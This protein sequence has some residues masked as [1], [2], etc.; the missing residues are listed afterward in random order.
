M[1][2]TRAEA[3]SLDRLDSIGTGLCRPESV[4]THRSGLVFTSDWTAGGGVSVIAPDGKV[5]RVLSDR[6]ADPLRPNGI[7]LLE[8]G[9]FLLAHLGAETGGLYEMDATGQFTPVI[10]HL[11]G[12]P[13]PPSNF[14]LLD[15]EGDLWLT[16][17]TRLTPR[18]AAYRGDVADGFV[19]HIREGRAQ[20]AADGLGY[21]NECLRSPDGSVLYV[22]ET[23]ARRLTAF[24]VH[25]D[26][27]LGNRRVVATFGRG[28]FPDGLAMDVEGA[29]WVTS[30]V[31]NRVI[32]VTPDGQQQLML[33]DAD[34]A[35]LV[36]VEA[37]FVA[38]TMDRPHLDRAAGQRLAN[39][40][41]L[42]FGGDDL[43]QAH[44]GCL[45][46]TTV[47]RFTSPVAGHQPP[48]WTYDLGPLQ[49][50]AG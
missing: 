28:T 15:A 11:A 32:R 8:G 10:T 7:A 40:S 24:D 3:L 31:S 12:Q 39:I 16:V 22:N 23:F 38:R 18:A 19:L 47:T 30:I 20:I 4:V 44:L 33:E 36:D 34:P 25:A 41:S 21:T 27:S 5:T 43:R 37:A 17:S 1:D 42:A 9:R 48:H 46:G 6:I 13:L 14:P 2:M 35:H 29:L 49:A 50:L 26:G 45:L